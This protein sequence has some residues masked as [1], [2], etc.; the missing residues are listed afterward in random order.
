MATTSPLRQRMIEDDPQPLAGDSRS[1][2]PLSIRGWGVVSS[3]ATARFVQRG[4]PHWPLD[5]ESGHL[6]S[7]NSGHSPTAWRTGQVDPKR[8]FQT[9]STKQHLH[10]DFGS[11]EV[12]SWSN[13]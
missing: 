10:V 12:D 6:L 5:V 8:T 3:P 1:G 2:P 13:D 7:A 4:D 9:A 11:V